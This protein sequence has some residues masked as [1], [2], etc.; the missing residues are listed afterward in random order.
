M[1]LVKD[2]SNQIPLSFDVSPSKGRD[3]LISSASVEAAVSVLDLWPN[4]R[5]HIV[6]LAGPTGSGKSHIAHVWREK[7]VAQN[8][9]FSASTDEIV[10]I[11]K[12]SPIL[13]EDIDRQDMDETKFFHLLNA[14]KEAQ[15]SILITS[16]TWPASWPIKLP[17]LAS[18]IKSATVVEIGEPDEMLLTHVIFKLFADRQI[19][20]DEKIVNYLVMRMERS[21]AVAQNIVERMD[22]LALSKKVPVSRAIAADVLAELEMHE[23]DMEN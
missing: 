14:V 9:E 15:S 11:C 17:D 20:I 4:W 2:T 18:R 13:L 1:F 10:T 16:R 3:D 7:A 23:T 6:I 12:Q 5:S 19:E 8:I 22:H 21:L